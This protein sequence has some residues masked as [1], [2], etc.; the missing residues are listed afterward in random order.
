M[1]GNP[2]KKQDKMVLEI[3]EPETSPAGRDAER[4]RM[5]RSARNASL[6]R[7]EKGYSVN[8]WHLPNY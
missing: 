8:D 7:A 4:A 5:A 1:R 6:V 3:S 2:A